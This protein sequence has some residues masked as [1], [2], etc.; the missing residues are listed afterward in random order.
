MPVFNNSG[1]Q[2]STERASAE[3]FAQATRV[4]GRRQGPAAALIKNRNWRGE[5][6]FSLC[7]FASG[8]NLRVR[9]SKPRKQ[10]EMIMPKTLISVAMLAFADLAVVPAYASPAPAPQAAP[11]IAVILKAQARSDD[12]AGRR[13]GPDRDRH[14][15]TPG[16]RYDRAPSHWH[17][18]HSRPRDWRRR[19]CII[20]GPL[21]F[22][23]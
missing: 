12:Y 4:C 15:F 10:V 20:V 5:H 3:Q 8:G 22:C 11:A 1:V 21:W 7:R 19:G 17:R 9:R 23:P 18:Y 6:P 13:R 14:R 16:H 2:T